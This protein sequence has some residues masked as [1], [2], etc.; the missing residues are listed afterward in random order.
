LSWRFR[1]P[2]GETINFVD[3]FFGRQEFVA[4]KDFGDFV[5]WRNDDVPLYW[6]SV[7]R[8]LAEKANALLPAVFV[9]V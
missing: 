6:F 8:R 7:K 2:D 5:V 9:S 3:G 4:G 1:V